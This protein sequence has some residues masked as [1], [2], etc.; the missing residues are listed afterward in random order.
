MEDRWRPIKAIRNGLKLKPYTHTPS[1]IF[2]FMKSHLWIDS[3]DT[4]RLETNEVRV[5]AGRESSQSGADPV[6][7]ARKSR[8]TRAPS[9]SVGLSL[10]PG[11]MLWCD[12]TWH[13]T[14]GH[15]TLVTRAEWQVR[16]QNYQTDNTARMTP[17][18]RLLTGR[19]EFT[20]YTIVFFIHK[21]NW[22]IEKF[23]E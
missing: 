17:K 19:D 13:V 12:V 15:V 16:Y 6:S 4:R 18:T 22:K 5:R 14:P 20:K 3:R 23:I 2:L 8:K 1:K 21:R 9:L 11:V 10:S 7:V